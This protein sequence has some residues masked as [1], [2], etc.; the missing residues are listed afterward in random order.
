MLV[1]LHVHHVTTCVHLVI[2]QHQLVYLVREIEYRRVF[3]IVQA[4]FKN[5]FYIKERMTHFKQI[6][7]LAVTCVLIAVLLQ[8]IVRFAPQIE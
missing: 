8:Q 7:P 3:V 4:V 6:V 1:L 5:L 2:K